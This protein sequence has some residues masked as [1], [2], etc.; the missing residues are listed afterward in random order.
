MI[1]LKR[2]MY[3]TL[4]VVFIAVFLF[5]GGYLLNYFLN[6]RQ[7]Q[8]DY[9]KLANLVENVTVPT[10]PTLDDTIGSTDPTATA[11]TIPAHVDVVDP[12]TGETVSVLYQYAPIYELNND[13]IGWI[14]VDGTNIN[15]P[16]VQTPDSKNYYLKRNFDGAYSIHGTI[17]A[18]EECDVFAPS[19]N[20]TLYGHR[21]NDGT[22]FAGLL[23]YKKQA[24]WEQNRYISFDTLQEQHTYEIFAV[25]VIRE[26]DGHPFQYHRFVDA[27]NQAEFDEFISNCKKYDLYDTGITPQYG[28]KILTLSTC[29]RYVANGRVAVFA[30]LVEDA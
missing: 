12:E 27:K 11:E 24:F 29:E 21:M 15:Y 14:R 9:D 20:V 18:Q 6:S 25:V 1:I 13:L 30:R 28:D 19:D 10:T 26:I 22:M 5:S 17:Y 3:I 23:S 7:A 2:W 16:V 4:M 8:S